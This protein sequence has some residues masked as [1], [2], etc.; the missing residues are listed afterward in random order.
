MFAACKDP[1]KKPLAT[2]PSFDSVIAR[3]E[4]ISDAGDK[5]GGLSYA[6]YNH[7][8]AGKLTIQDEMNYYTYVSEVYRKDLQEVDHFVAYSDS[9]IMLLERQGNPK[10]YADRYVQAYAMKA[11]ALF[12]KG[13]YNE[14]YDYYYK[15][16]VEAGLLKDSCN[17][18]KLTYSLGMILYK[19]QRYAEAADHFLESYKE[20]GFCESNFRV[21]YRKQELLDNIGLS[22]YGSKKYDS[23]L[24]Y[25]GLALVCIDSNYLKYPLKDEA[26]Y[27]TAKAVIYGNIGNVYIALNKLDSAELLL[28]KSININ[29]QK[30]YTNSDALVEQVKLATLCYKTG[31]IDDMKQ[32]LE[33]IRVEL[34]TIP[35]RNITMAWN[36]LMW[37]YLEKTGNV[38]ASYPYLRKYVV[39]SDSFA[40]INKKMMATDVDERIRNMERQNK[41]NELKKKNEMTKVY[42]TVAVVIAVMALI[43]VIQVLANIRRARRNVKNLTELNSKLAALNDTVYQQNLKLEDAL[44][45]VETKD[46]D[47]N[48]ILRSV[49]HDVMNPIAAISSL[50]DILSESGTYTDDQVEILELI[51][52]ACSNSLSLSKDIIEAASRIESAALVKEWVNINK[53]VSNAVKLLSVHAK[54]KKQKITFVQHTE[55]VEAY[56]SKKKI[57]RV[58]N[59]LVGNAIKFSHEHSEI[60]IHLVTILDTIHLTVIDKGVG[61]PAKNI[62]HIFEMFTEAKTVGTS[63]EVPHGLGLSISMQ[64]AKAHGGN[65]WVES[66]E[67]KGSAFH[68]EIPINT[69]K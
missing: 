1:G 31:K 46:K 65:I 10:E 36:K 43:I 8:T 55:N 27:I 25:Y 41:I 6:I 9:I 30:G 7:A 53:L 32:E 13:L 29:I 19:Q 34:D 52:E 69:S 50:T 26:A 60:E 5:K 18:S 23:A 16:K 49:A 24:Y 38:E 67:G 17:M 40:A 21:F 54:A 47:K 56:V 62:P 45:E 14:S 48:R 58:V 63:G 44:M 15:A 35:D 61:I 20:V 68:L 2:T 4:H 22:Y 64:I 59:N 42:M 28:E 12:S 51:K 66:E 39:L 11:E 3:A 33:K 37:Q 57:W